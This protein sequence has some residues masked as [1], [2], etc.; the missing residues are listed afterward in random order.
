MVQLAAV[1]KAGM[2]V[3]MQRGGVIGTHTKRQ[4]PRRW[5]TCS[6]VDEHSTQCGATQPLPLPL[7]ID[8]ERTQTERGQG[9]IVARHAARMRVNA[10]MAHGYVVAQDDHRI[11][12]RTVRKIGQRVRDRA[13]P[14]P[15]C[16]QHLQIEQCRMLAHVCRH[17]ANGGGILHAGS[18]G[19]G[20]VPWLL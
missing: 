7:G 4:L 17:D 8:E 13:D 11:A 18:D 2:R 19:D 10:V 5:I 3:Q 1:D 14:D 16:R 15:L 6:E 9:E 12:V 20:D